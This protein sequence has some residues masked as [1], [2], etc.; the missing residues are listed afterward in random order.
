MPLGPGTRLGPY[1]VIAAIGAGGMGEVYRARDTKLN[2]DVALKILP[3]T[4]ASDPDRLARFHREAQVLASLN[5]PHIAAIYGF[6]DS[7]D[8]HA[9]V[10]ELVD[11]PTLADR[12]AQGP[13]PVDEALVIA[14]QIAEALEAAHEQGIIHRDLKPANIKVKSDG[15]VKVL[16]FGLAKLA[17]PG[18]G[19]RDSGFDAALSMSP[20]ITSP[21]MMTGVGVMLGTAAYMSPEQ[22]KG[23]PADKR[24]DIW[25]FGCVFYEMLTGTRP[26]A[27]DDVTETI[28]AIVRGDPDWTALPGNTP[29]AIRTLLQRCL[30]KDTKL[31]FR[32]AG[33]IAIE[34]RDALTAIRTGA[35]EAASRSAGLSRRSLIVG[36]S[37]LLLGSLAGGTAVWRA[38]SSSPAGV[39]RFRMM[40][41]PGQ[42][43]AGLDLIAATFAP[44]GRHFV[45]V[46][47]TGG[48]QELYLGALDNLNAVP[49]ANTEGAANP[50]FSPDGQWVGFFT[51]GSL[52]K[53]A[54]SGGPAVHLARTDNFG[55]GAAWGPDG[56][57]VF[58]PRYDDGLW[59]IRDSGGTPRRLTTLDRGKSEGS[60]RFPQYL[61]DGRSI[62][63]TVGTGGSWDDARIEVL[64][65]DSGERTVVIQ[66]GSDARYVPT[67]HLIY[68]RGGAL[69]AVPF[70]VN[71]SAVGGRPTTVVDTLLPSTNNTGSAQATFSNAGSLMYVAGGAGS[72][73]RTLRWVDR[74]GTEQRLPLPGRSYR[75]PR[76]S[77]DG[78]RIVLDIDEG[79]KSD[80]W[81]YDLP[82]GTL[83]RSTFDG[84]SQFSA[85][86]GDGRKV[87]FLS[88]NGAPPNLFWKNADGSG[89]AEQLTTGR[90]QQRPGNWAAAGDVFAFSDS[91]PMTGW[92]L[93]TLSLKGGR[94]AQPFVQTPFNETTPGF[95]PD[96]RWIAYQSDESGRTE[97]YVQP[98]PGTG[99]K[100]L[101]STDG[102]AEPV[103]SGDGRELFYRNGDHMMAASITVQ[104]DL[105]IAKPERLFDKRTWTLT[106]ARNYDVTRDGRRFL[107]IMESDQV[108][109]ANH[110]NVELN[111]FDELKRLVPA[112]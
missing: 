108:A 30:Q 12:I 49:I 22:A 79:N 93:W 97:V 33:D 81:I 64:K 99:S 24:A 36:F 28:A 70:D 2:R 76:L 90:H 88:A 96:G 25:A 109:A 59:I 21:A 38:R 102:G 15:S 17:E 63:F 74:A 20:T 98:F 8:T 43:L 54:V 95:S 103:W 34:C 1:E 13:I 31:R 58:A 92:D 4:F 11:G 6:E 32:D 83:T 71:A 29:S 52:N 35:A 48:P 55:R 106:G 16:D 3:P 50:F 10:L 47:T 14:T 65:I 27:G 84:L 37:G 41:G 57:I 107:M 77:P 82:R 105:R 67:G 51:D 72:S 100:I 112:K 46:A 101:V 111:W 73:E 19:T 89:V 61:P 94:K 68:Q 91:D 9:L 85:W 26:F 75:H 44:D 110:I 56:S 66:G 42:R 23:R 7:G 5:H 104:A 53:V 87:M 78:Q 40:L 39:A 86:S 18:F 60:H 69:L 62:L 80:V 45:Y